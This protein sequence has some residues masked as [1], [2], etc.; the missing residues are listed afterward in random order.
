MGM[1]GTKEDDFFY[2]R[3]ESTT[4]EKTKVDRLL[5]KFYVPASCIMYLSDFC[6]FLLCIC[7][8]ERRGER[9]A[10]E[11]G[12]LEKGDRMYTVSV[13]IVLPGTVNK[14]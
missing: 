2:G 7:G 8:W 3:R 1:D 9:G 6:R 13:L 10:G 4:R 12:G 11:G 5:R 14:Y